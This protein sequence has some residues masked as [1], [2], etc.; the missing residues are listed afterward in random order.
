MQVALLMRVAGCLM[1][2]ICRSGVSAQ[3]VRAPIAAE[4]LLL[5]AYS[6]SAGS[7]PSPGTNP[8]AIAFCT[9]PAASIYSE[10]RYLLS[11]LALYHVAGVLPAAGGTVALY[12]GRFG[13]NERHES[14]LGLAYGR[15]LGMAIAIGAG[16]NWFSFA[17]K[18]YRSYDAVNFEMGLMLEI[19]EQLR[20]G[21][22]MYNPWTRTGS[23]SERDLLP[24]E[25]SFGVGWTVASNFSIS[26]LVS[27]S[28]AGPVAL[29]GGFEYQFEKGYLA[30]TG[31]NA[32]AG[33][34]Y[35]GSGIRVHHVQIDVTASLHPQLGVSPGLRV[36]WRKKQEE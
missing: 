13:G 33:T 11:Q 16:F 1:L 12:G 18:G 9:V 19:S 31:F 30:R 22:Q 14:G 32:A 24:S 27:K 17:T 7:D 34:Y 36:A 3:S 20:A 21:V 25:F 35:L 15:K 5:D 6:K 29:S 10:R 8:A 2:I 4:H 26:A 28:D 23:K